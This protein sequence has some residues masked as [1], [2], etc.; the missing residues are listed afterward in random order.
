MTLIQDPANPARWTDDRWTPGTPGTFAVVIGASRYRHLNS[1][2]APA[3]QTYELGQLYVCALT[4]HRFF[5]WLRDGYR[6]PAAPLA[7]VWLLLAPSAEERALTEAAAPKDAEFVRHL[8]AGVVEP[9]AAAC[10]RSIREW[11]YEM[12]QLPQPAS[13][14]S[15]AFFFFTGHGLEVTQ[16]EQILLPSDYLQ[17]PSVPEDAIVVRNLRDGLSAIP[18]R[19]Q[20]FFLD[21]C[22]NDHQALRALRR[23]GRTILSEPG[24]GQT[25]PER[26]LSILYGSAAGTQAWSPRDPRE[27]PSVFGQ[28]LLEGL[29]AEPG[30]QVEC[31][32]DPPV[33]AILTYDL[34]KFV[35]NRVKALLE[36]RG[37]A[38]RQYVPLG[39]SRIDDPAVTQVSGP[40]RPAPPPE[41]QPERGRDEVFPTRG[42][43]GGS[44]FE[45]KL[46]TRI[47]W[48]LGGS[49][50]ADAPGAPGSLYEM[51]R[52]EQ[53]TAA[54]DSL[55]MWSLAESRWLERDEYPLHRVERD[56]GGQVFRVDVSLPRARGHV[57]M[58]LDAFGLRLASVLATDTHSAPDYRILLFRDP[59]KRQVTGMEV[60]LSPEQESG[61]L[62]QAAALW[63]E[64]RAGNVREVAH[65]ALMVGHLES[66]LRS[67]MMS[68]L[69][70]TVAGLILLRAGEYGRMHDWPRNL[71]EWFPD[72]PDG[73]VIWAEQL[74]RSGGGTP[75]SVAEAGKY[76]RMAAER[77]LPATSEAVGYLSTHLHGDAMGPEADWLARRL[78]Y[79]QSGG[80][81]TVL[82]GPPGEVTH[83]LAYGLNQQPA[84]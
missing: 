50:P 81:F 44:F 65:G 68:P 58:Q 48:N 32:G 84:E 7:G 3:A 39:G 66:L 77:G 69:A 22:R 79:F 61:P 63:D 13:E 55:R 26:N 37:A 38:V 2:D 52:S 15:R 60:R 53:V 59:Q 4:A 73:A 47:G 67:K 31:D 14:A 16:E 46:N 72:R 36:A 35:K 23:M 28:A 5:R 64:Y 33:C 76:A 30:V 19:D 51:L 1:G 29:Q 40:G 49:P 45:V 62:R 56:A 34:H 54:F 27:G 80:L 18:V 12:Q 78:A 8:Q 41:P 82:M 42:D 20:F 75:N 24:S 74:L 57:W 83:E 25:Y 9:T 11:F 10:E 17:P 71:A 43:G 21:A 70:A 6:N